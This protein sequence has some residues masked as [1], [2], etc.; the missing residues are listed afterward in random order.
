MGVWSFLERLG[1]TGAASQ[2]VAA[3]VEAFWEAARTATYQTKWE[4]LA[5]VEAMLA[6]AGEER[7]RLLVQCAKLFARDGHYW[8]RSFVGALF[9]KLAD[10]KFPY[11]VD[12]L[13]AITGFGTAPPNGPPLATLLALLEHGYAE[14]ELPVALANACRELQIRLNP[15][16]MNGDIRKVQE[17]V[18]RLLRPVN[19]RDTVHLTRADAWSSELCDMLGAL[20]PGDRERL[21]ALLVHVEHPAGSKP[22]GRW[23]KTAQ[24]AVEAFGAERFGATMVRVLERVGVSGG[25]PVLVPSFYSEWRPAD[26]TLIS[27]KHSDLLKG[28]I[29]ALAPQ[30]DA[31]A[32]QALGD[33]A[34]RCFKKVPGVGPRAPKIGNA[35]LQALALARAPNAVAQLLRRQRSELARQR[36][37]SAVRRV[38]AVVRLR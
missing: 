13:A 3:P 7:A 26:P 20:E 25:V 6:T 35:C 4:D 14:R 34:E 15:H 10:P 29:W 17:R 37:R 19:E 24:A 18:A 30:A 11:S 28:L 16:G 1:L 21:L 5:G 22:S 32:V 31:T 2:S 8:T 38:L 27:P 33:A 12:D 9:Q 23:L 36:R